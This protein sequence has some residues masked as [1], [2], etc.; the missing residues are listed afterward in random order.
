MHVVLKVFL[1]AYNFFLYVLAV[2]CVKGAMRCY[3]ATQYFV[4]H[5]IIYA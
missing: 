1:S 5:E 2:A 3:E 4:L